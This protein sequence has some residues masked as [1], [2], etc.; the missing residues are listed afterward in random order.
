MTATHV[1]NLGLLVGNAFSILTDSLGML[2]RSGKM[3]AIYT[4]SLFAHS[5]SFEEEGM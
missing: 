1:Y 3:S 4:I 5:K 2:F